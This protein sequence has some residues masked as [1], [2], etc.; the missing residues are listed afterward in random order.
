MEIVVAEP[1]FWWRVSPANRHHVVAVDPDLDDGHQ[2][3]PDRDE[4]RWDRI[5]KAVGEVSQALT[6]G[7]WVAD[8]DE[9][10]EW[11]ATV[12]IETKDLT[13]TEHR[14]VQEWF[15]RAQPV[16]M[17]PWFSPLSNGRHRLWN[18]GPHF[19][20]TLIPVKGDSIGYANPD[21]MAAL[22]ERGLREFARNVEALQ[23]VSWFD[24]QDP[25]NLRFIAHLEAAARG[26]FPRP[27]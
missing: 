7:A 26:E 20:S 11:R 17:D 12:E 2:R 27:A 6:D 24:H 22:G 4:Q 5:A 23:Q 21:D 15:G 1:N 16:R 3:W 14:I 25:V 19:E 8:T 18:A 9:G 13:Q 10:W